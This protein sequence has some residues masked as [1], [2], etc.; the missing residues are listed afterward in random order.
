MSFPQSSASP[1]TLYGTG[2][3]NV[4]KI[5]LMLE[6]LS[7][8]YRFEHVSVWRGEQHAEPIRALN[9]NARLPI[10]TGAGP[11][12]SEPFA[13]FESGAILIHLAEQAQRFLPA[14]GIGRYDVLQWLM[15]QVSGLGPAF[16]QHIHFTRFEPDA[17]AY[18]RARYTSEA[19]RLTDVFEK[20]LEGK[21]YLCGGEYSI[22]DMAAYPWLSRL[23]EL[24][25]PSEKPNIKRWCSHI[26]R[27]PAALKMRE[28]AEELR[29]ET[30][31]MRARATEDDLDRLFGRGRYRHDL[32]A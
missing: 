14:K 30:A 6:E 5:V 23:E 32:S 24:K 11:D 26:A 22:A 4:M 19:A 1:Y 20:R 10:L 3:S 17:S 29:K 9:P 27:R 16:G 31:I 7:Q 12:G 18:A 2:S 13:V 28:I 15:L 21:E 25:L 8:P